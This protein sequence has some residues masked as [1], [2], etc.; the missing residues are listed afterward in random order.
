MLCKQYSILYIYSCVTY[1][2]FHLCSF[3]VLA[4]VEVVCLDKTPVLVGCAAVLSLNILRAWFRLL[5]K[6]QECQLLSRMEFIKSFKY[7]VH[8]SL[9]LRM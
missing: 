5:R 7:E 3:G 4:C 8:V 9:C 1:V 6:G 2:L